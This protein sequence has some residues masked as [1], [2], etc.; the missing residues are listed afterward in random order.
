MP[1][2]AGTCVDTGTAL[3]YEWPARGRG[4]QVPRG[5]AARERA[6]GQAPTET[7]GKD[8]SRVMSTGTLSAPPAGAMVCCAIAGYAS[9][10]LTAETLTGMRKP[11]SPLTGQPLPA[12][13]LKHADDQTVAA[14]A[15]VSEAIR[16]HN[17]A[18][19]DF[20]NWG[21]VAAPRFL[22]RATMGQVLHRFRQEGAW[23]ISPHLIPHRSLHAV[24]GTLSLALQIHGPNFGVGA[25][26]LAESEG[27]AVAAAL[28]G[29]ENVPG[30]WVVLT[31]YDPEI[32]PPDPTSTVPDAE[33]GY[34]PPCIAIALAL[35]TPDAAADGLCLEV[36]QPA[37]TGVATPG[38]AWPMLTLGALATALTEGQER[39][40]WRLGCGGWALL[41][42][43][44][45]E[46]YL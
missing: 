33:A 23:G 18:N 24:S 22:G 25:G 34:V 27:L 11:L 30:V 32:I 41:K 29:S 40:A 26:P 7:T 4:S 31:G 42:R 2:L 16:K 36:G 19:R 37:A 17:L 46:N 5:A 13:L 38:D 15:A 39:G 8:S 14:L 9:L 3:Q 44:A 43:F 1:W 12:T 10:R 21:V 20:R 6:P 45:A 28:V 35:T